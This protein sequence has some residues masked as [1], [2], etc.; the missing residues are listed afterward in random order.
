MKN[1]RISVLHIPQHGI[2]HLNSKGEILWTNEEQI[3][4]LLHDEGE[5]AILSAYF[6]TAY[7]G[8][9]APPANLYLGLDA[10]ESL[11][12]ADTLASLS[13]EPNGN[14]YARIALST[15]GTG[16][17]GQDFVI[18]Q[19]VASYQAA[20]KIVTFTCTDLAWSGVTKLFLCTV[21]TGT[22]GKLICSLPLSATR[23][24]QVGD[25]LQASM[26]LGLSEP[27]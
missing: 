10:R 9:G 27:A 8:Y 18:S 6:A 13:G 1:N 2:K 26:T 24:L 15:A 23:T 16:V 5:Q 22:A 19:P 4:N 25:S 20:S 3:D 21:G 12:E 14:G 17:A 11:A 7:T